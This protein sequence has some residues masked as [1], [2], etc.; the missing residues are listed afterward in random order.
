MDWDPWIAWRPRVEFEIRDVWMGVYWDHKE[1]PNFLG[2]MYESF[3]KTM[4]EAHNPELWETTEM[5]DIYIC[6][7]PFFPIHFHF[8]RTGR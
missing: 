3:E 5:I 2:E 1:E 8:E 6:L 7:V 4:Y